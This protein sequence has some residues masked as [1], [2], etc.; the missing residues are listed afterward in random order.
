[1]TCIITYADQHTCTLGTRVS[2]KKK[3][4]EK[5]VRNS[6]KHTSDRLGRR[7]FTSTQNRVVCLLGET[8]GHSLLR[9]LET[10]TDEA[11]TKAMKGKKRLKKE[12]RAC[13]I[14]IPSK[15]QRKKKNRAK[16]HVLRL[17]AI[18]L[19]TWSIRRSRTEQ[20]SPYAAISPQRRGRKRETVA[21][22]SPGCNER[23]PNV[24]THTR[25]T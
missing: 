8:D 21:F 22:S 11:G 9:I 4:N 6:E 25:L 5:H 12:A 1:M 3:H 15:K 19:R 2:P 10:D 20:L 17:K 13:T 16:V 18:R 23:A 7:R 24:H 14:S